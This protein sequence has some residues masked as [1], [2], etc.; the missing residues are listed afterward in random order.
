MTHHGCHDQVGLPAHRV[1]GA[2]AGGDAGQGRLLA[3]QEHLIAPV[4]TLLVGGA[5]DGR[6]AHVAAD[7]AGAWIP[8]G[9]DQA[10]Q[11]V[12]GPSWRWASEKARISPRATATAAFWAGHL[13]GAG[14]L[15]HPVRTGCPRRFRGWRRRSRRR[16]RSPRGRGS[17]A[18]AGWR[19]GRRSRPPR[20]RRRRSPRRA[21]ARPSS[22]R[23]PGGASGAPARPGGVRSRPGR[24]RAAPPPART[25]GRLAV[26]AVRSRRRTASVCAGRR[27]PGVEVLGG[28]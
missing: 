6:E 4:D 23:E 19:P 21:A 28:L 3:A 9:V 1:N 20:G 13:A 16:R 25:R 8:E 18:R 12:G 14:Q 27:V 2:V 10:R 11:R 5:V 17:R 26:I 22:G 24:R 15:Q 7:I